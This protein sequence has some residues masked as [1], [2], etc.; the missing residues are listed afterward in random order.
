MN[1]YYPFSETGA[2]YKYDVM[3][4]FMHELGH[5]LR[6][7]HSSKMEDSVGPYVPT[8]NIECRTPTAADIEAVRVST[9]RWFN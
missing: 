4:I 6:V 8:G 7:D 2:A 3:S 9:K 5:I 1:T